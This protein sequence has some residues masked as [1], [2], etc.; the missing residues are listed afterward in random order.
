VLLLRP[1]RVAVHTDTPGGSGQSAEIV[2]SVY[3]G[4]VTRLTLRLQ[5]GAALNVKYL[6]R[7][8]VASLAPGTQVHV[9]WDP[10]DA[11]LLPAEGSR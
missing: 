7:T 4:D 3:V 8:G 6:N 11:I 2:D 1:E 10:H 5:G 9:T